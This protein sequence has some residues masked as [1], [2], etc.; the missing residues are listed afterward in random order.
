MS[1][2]SFLFILLLCVLLLPVCDF[3]SDIKDGL[4]YEEYINKANLYLS[5][6]DAE[7][8]ILAYKK[9]LQIKSEDGKIHFALGELYEE[10]WRKSYDL[11]HQKYQADVLMYPNKRQ[12]KNMTEELRKFGLKD[13]YKKLA[14]E[15]YKAVVKYCPENWT[16]RY[17]I[18]T[19]H[20]NNKRYK[21]AI[22]EYQRVIDL[23]PDF[24]NSYGLIGEAYFETN[25]YDLAIPYLEKAIQL[26][27]NYAYAYYTLGK[28]YLAMRNGE[29]V[30]EILEKLKSMNSTYF[31]ELRLYMFSK[32]RK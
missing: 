4:T 3:N 21:E 5:K 24:S 32:E 26:D 28:V 11:A 12:N 7:K 9:A 6:G 25:F 14:L 27:A 31:D 8:A 19:D 13:E 29:K 10:E 20:L 22:S 15:E 1:K 17:R 18:A 30:N 2:V 23:N 16:A